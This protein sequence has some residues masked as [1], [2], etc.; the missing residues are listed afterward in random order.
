MEQTMHVNQLTGCHWHFSQPVDLLRAF[1]YLFL[2]FICFSLAVDKHKSNLHKNEERKTII[3]SIES[4]PV[5][6][7]IQCCRKGFRKLQKAVG[8]IQFWECLFSIES[9]T[10]ESKQKGTI[11]CCK[12]SNKSRLLSACILTFWI[13]FDF[14]CCTIYSHKM[15]AWATEKMHNLNIY[16]FIFDEI[17]IPEKP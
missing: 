12:A 7:Y 4:I 6:L 9:R 11:C 10:D 3:F 1:F 14:H 2:F 5:L 16:F 17:P 8:T 15:Y 13:L